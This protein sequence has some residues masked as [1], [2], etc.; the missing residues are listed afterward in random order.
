MAAVQAQTQAHEHREVDVALV[1]ES[2]YPYLKGGVSAVVHDIVEGNQDLTF[3]IIHITWDSAAPHEDLYGMPANVKWVQPVYLSMQEHLHDFVSLTPRLLGM[4]A[5]GR[6]RLSYRIYDALDAI[7]NGDPD[8]MWE[9]YDE[10]INP[11]TRKYPIWAVLGTKEFMA[12]TRDRLSGLG[13]SLVDTFWLL[14]EFFSLACAVTSEEF[15]RARVYHAHT[16]GY[17]ALLGA[18][19][20][21]QNGTSF[22][23]TEHNLY[24][25]DTVNLMLERSMALTLDARDWRDFDV[26]PHQRAWMAW[27]IEMGRFCYPSAE[28]ITYLYPKAIAEA[29]GLGA[30]VEKSM[31]IPNGMVVRN[32]DEAFKQRVRGRQ[33]IAEDDGGRVWRLVYIARVV[34]IKGLADLI[35][36]V[37]LLVDRGITNFHLDILGPTDHF[38]DYYMM[39]R[40]KARRLNVEDY[41]TFRGTVNVGEVLGQFDILTL[42]SYNEGQPIVVLEAMVAG[43]PVAGTAVGGM[44]QLIQD[45]LTTP[46]GR[47]WESCGLLVRP[48]Y[49]IGMADALQTLMRDKE[50]YEQFATNARGR[51]E[52]FFQLED[53]MGA[54]NRLY[55][56]L[57]GIASATLEEAPQST[58]RLAAAEAEFAPFRPYEDEDVTASG[59]DGGPRTDA[60]A[61]LSPD[62]V[63][64]LIERDHGRTPESHE[65]RQA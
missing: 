49:I 51:V 22:L 58:E 2:T 21:R 32:F 45:P 46:G 41:M 60:P 13:L 59:P 7:L 3:G 20:A 52:A 39:C 23:L 17:A 61:P 5:K 44:Q 8:P 30:P 57:G 18:A 43:I 35:E 4:R 36:S 28:A 11:R 40:E 55:K 42:P 62:R 27:W 12:V 14:R 19:A 34:P 1:M 65:P 26:T 53:A 47:T 25:R 54:Y 29:A 63:I 50:M 56:E 31:V 15:P 10:G 48:D 38:P 33:G 37:S 16:T 9:L 64:D 6:F 24:V